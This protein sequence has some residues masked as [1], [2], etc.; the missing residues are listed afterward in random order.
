VVLTAN[1]RVGHAVCEYDVIEGR[2][3]LT[4]L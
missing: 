3:Y 4:Q 1:D 2:A